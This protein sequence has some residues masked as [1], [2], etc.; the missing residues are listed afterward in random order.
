MAS[1]TATRDACACPAGMSSDSHGQWG[2][3]IIYS[4][5]TWH[6]FSLPQG[7][8][9]SDLGLRSS[10]SGGGGGGTDSVRALTMA[11]AVRMAGVTTYS[12]QRP[13]SIAVVA[14]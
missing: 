5:C 4:P 7:I 11:L 3:P 8:T 1:D 6:L 12:C 14:T 13:C 2:G 10:S 9:Y